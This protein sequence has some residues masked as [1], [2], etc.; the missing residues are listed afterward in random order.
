MRDRKLVTR[1]SHAQEEL[2]MTLRSDNFN[3]IAPLAA[4]AL[5]TLWFAS[6]AQAR[7]ENLRWT[8]TRASEVQRFEVRVSSID[9]SSSQIVDLGVPFLGSTGVYDTDVEVGDGDVRIEMRAFGPGGVPSIWTQP[10]TRLGSSGGGSGSGTVSVPDGTTIPPVTGADQRFDFEADAVGSN[11]SE[12]I[13][14]RSNFSLVQNNSLF[15]VVQLGTN[16]VLHTSSAQT[17][18]HSHAQGAGNSW[19]NFRMTG[20]MAI[21]ESSGRVGVTTYSEYPSADRYY[22]LANANGGSFVLEGRPGTLT[23]T[24]SDTGVTPT[25]GTWYHFKFDVVDRGTY[26]QIRA[27]IWRAGTSEPA[28]FQAECVD[29]TSTRTRRGS[30]GVYAA[31]LGQKYWDDLELIEGSVVPTVPPAPPVLLQVVPAQP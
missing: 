3:R 11:V 12:W 25:A 6:T 1:D 2:A 19:T 8:H 4:A 27:R 14:T 5:I 30:I 16:R 9:G 18:I 15:D 28:N 13:D 24:T 26:N 20:R 23:C 31:G 29:E 10:Q 21:D 17:A 22:R 7:P